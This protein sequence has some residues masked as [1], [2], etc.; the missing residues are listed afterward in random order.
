M[1]FK[2]LAIRPLKDCNEKFLKNLKENQ[3]YQFY[4]EYKFCY[5]NN[6]ENEEVIKIKKLKQS[7]PDD[8]FGKNINISAIVGKN[9]SGKSSLVEL[10]IVSI[11]QLSYHLKVNI[12]STVKGKGELLTTADLKLAKE[13]SIKKINCEFF[14][15]KDSE[16]YFIKIKDN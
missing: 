12:E 4:N 2:L 15:E 11:N 9:G 5:K 6:D 8:F 16:F 10:F 13:K 3:I 1:S 7:V 14:F